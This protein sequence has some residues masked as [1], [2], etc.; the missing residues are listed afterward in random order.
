MSTDGYLD[1]PKTALVLSGGGLKGLAH[2]GAWRALT[3][4]GIRPDLIVGTSIGAF[5]GGT[6]ACGRSVDELESLALGVG[7]KEIAVLDRLAVVMGGVR[8][9]SAYR[10]DVLRRYLEEVLSFHSFSELT[11]PLHVGA[12]DLRRGELA[13]FG[14]DPWSPSDVRS[15]VSLVDAIL[16]S[17]ALPAFYPPVRIG[18]SWYVDGG[19]LDTFPVLRAAEL[20]AEWIVGVDVTTGEEEQ[21]PGLLVEDGMLAVTQR[22]FGVMASRR[23]AEVLREWDGPPLTHVRPRV[24]GVDAFSF[25]HND[26]LVEEGYRATVA[27]LREEGLWKESRATG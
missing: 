19:V 7:P 10:G 14:V 23:R 13:W 25:D 26:Y 20:G 1:G 21:E 15:S 5:I 27:A 18:D 8:R 16:A 22:V 12:V 9:P 4:A 2:V 11:T 6:V 24:N 17:S 3:E